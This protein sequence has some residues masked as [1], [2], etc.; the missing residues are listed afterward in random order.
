MP[1]L[2]TAD[3]VFS[4][5]E[6]TQFA[7]IDVQLITGGHSAFTYRATLRNP[8]PTGESSIILKHAEGYIAVHEVM[9][10]EAERA[11]YEYESLAAVSKSGLFDSNSIV[12]APKPLHFDPETNTI[13][14]TDLG[15]VK[16]LTK[17]LTDSLEGIHDG[18]NAESKL[19]AACDL[20]SA[21][22]SALGDF[23]GRF[24]N[25]SSLPEQAALRK[26]F[27]QNVAG[28]KQ[29]LSIH[30]DMAVRAATMFGTMEPWLADIIEEEKQHAT[31]FQDGL[32]I[33]DLW[34]DNVLVSQG[35]EHGGLRLY[36]IDWEMAR[37]APPEFDMGE[38]TGAATSFARRYGVR[39]V[40]P[41]VPALHRAYSQHRTLDPL[42]I[43][44]LAGI[45]TMGFGT[46]LTWARDHTE[47]F[48]KQVTQEGYELLRLSKDR[49]V[50]AIRTQSLVKELF[51][52]NPQQMI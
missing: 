1:N 51:A 26:R 27:A 21:A 20:A 49:D 40:Y 29:C 12:Q 9:K 6:D 30:H 32:A 19:K 3:G 10:I 25:W 41:F 7:A 15:A 35:P 48:L 13:F 11:V 14:M 38:I 46:V 36:V 23:V 43:A 37:P 52:A 44:R 34:L 24:H 42:K 22:G 50:D 17:V 33:G 8:L 4:Y 47:E 16:T 18:D 2:T 31:G 5:L 39:E 28:T 45:D